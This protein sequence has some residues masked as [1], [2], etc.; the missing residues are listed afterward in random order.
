MKTEKDLDTAILK[1]TLEIKE[2]YPELSKYVLEMPVTIP[3][4][5]NPEVNR[6]A[7]QDYYNSLEALLNDY[8]ENQQK[9]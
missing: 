5:E 9:K 1:I 8:V 6:K 3:S 2:K 4:V 7:L